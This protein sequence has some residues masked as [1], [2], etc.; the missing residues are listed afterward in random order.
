M[1][2]SIIIIGDEILLGQ[3]ND[4]NSGFIA[5]NLAV[6]GWKT[7]GIETVG[8]NGDD[9]RAA[10]CRA[11]AKSD[12]IITTGGLGPTKDDITKPIMLEIFGGEMYRNAEVT[13]NIERVFKLRGL[14][15][16]TLTADQALVPSSC[17]VIQNRLGTAPIMWFERDGKVLVTMPGVP[18]ETE[19]M[20]VDAVI[21]AINARFNSDIIQFH[22]TLMVAG[23]TESNLALHLTDFEDS[24]AEGLHLAYLPKPGLIRLRLDGI[25]KADDL[26]FEAKYNATLDRLRSTL[27][28]LMIY[29]GDATPAEIALHLLRERGMTLATAESCTGGNIAH[30]ITLIAGSSDVFNGS[31]VSYS[32]AAK[33]DALGVKAATLDAHGAVSEPTVIEMAEGVRRALHADFAVATS[34]IA[35]PGGG[36]PDK[37]VGTVWTAVATPKGTVTRLLHLP[38]NRQ[39]VINRTTTEVLL[40]LI[41]QIR[42]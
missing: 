12:L 15:M 39:R 24:L 37:P 5:R 33:R 32:N 31:V 13:A 16:N 4:T 30:E 38:G 17:R 1:D 29:D 3:V 40:D 11:M 10:I 27:G 2:L 21:P 36:T 19:G 14:K 23:I 8:D 6:Q 9:I 18:F 7:V 20:L 22:H 25:A 35:G 42:K 26:A 28:D 41:A 34:G